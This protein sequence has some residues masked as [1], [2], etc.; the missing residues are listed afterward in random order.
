MA[1]I[2]AG[3]VL[4]A[5]VGMGAWWLWPAEQAPM[6]TR[7]PTVVNLAPSIE[8]PLYDRVEAVVQSGVVPRLV[9]LLGHESAAV[10]TPAL[11]TTGNIVSG[12]DSQTQ[13][14]V[15]AGALEAMAPLLQHA[16]KGIRR[17]ACMGRHPW[18]P[19]GRPTGRFTCCV[20]IAGAAIT[21][22]APTLPG[23]KRP[24]K[25]KCRDTR[26]KNNQ[27]IDFKKKF[28]SPVTWCCGRIIDITI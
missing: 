9:Q 28:R 5:L 10:V 26:Y 25:C 1:R 24:D 8:R 16:K 2:I 6:G 12:W 4:V 27:N 15:D 11:R 18:E 19:M 21:A 13:A 17:E 23:H 7:P 14:V 22:I 3:L 20:R